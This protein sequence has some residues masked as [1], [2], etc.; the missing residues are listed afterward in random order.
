M[1]KTDHSFL[2]SASLQI[3]WLSGGW[4]SPLNLWKVHFFNSLF[5]ETSPTV[6]QKCSPTLPPGPLLSRHHSASFQACRP[7]PRCKSHVDSP[8]LIL[9]YIYFVFWPSAS[10]SLKPLFGLHLCVFTCILL[11]WLFYL[12]FHLLDTKGIF[13][14][15]F[16]QIPFCWCL[17]VPSLV[18][19]CLLKFYFH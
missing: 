1:I 14:S 2:S 16:K 17:A 8:S 10:C 19:A 3:S 4:T 13:R 11:E 9:L 6:F 15:H 7:W 5:W 18:G 12:H